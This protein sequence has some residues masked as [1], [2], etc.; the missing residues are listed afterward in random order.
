MTQPTHAGGIVFRLVEKGPR[1][2]VTSSRKNPEHRVL[3]KGHIEPGET[4]EL[5]ALR[6][7]HEETGVSARILQPVG[8]ETYSLAGKELAVAFFLMEFIA[9]EESGEGRWI[10]WCSPEEADALL[11][12]ENSRAL[13]RQAHSMVLERLRVQQQM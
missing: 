6:E 12:F 9:G 5:A 11:T 2:L 10:G 4:R 13:L 1:Y 8:V 7:V 3:P